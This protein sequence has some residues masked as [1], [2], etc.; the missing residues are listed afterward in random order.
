MSNGS[1]IQP[2]EM[3]VGKFIELLSTFPRDMPLY[4]GT[5]FLFD[6]EVYDRDGCRT[7][8]TFDDWLEFDHIKTDKQIT[9]ANGKI[10]TRY[11]TVVEM[12]Y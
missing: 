12:K 11:V 3:T 8:V 10:E 5:K 1:S 2:D 4:F 7:S 9:R 6:D